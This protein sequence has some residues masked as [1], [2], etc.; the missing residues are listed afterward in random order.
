MLLTFD[1]VIAVLDDLAKAYR[2]T[3]GLDG[4]YDKEL[5]MAEAVIKK[6][7]DI[8]AQQAAYMQPEQMAE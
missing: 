6:F 2:Q 4:A 3:N 5:V 1:N 7:R 8:Q